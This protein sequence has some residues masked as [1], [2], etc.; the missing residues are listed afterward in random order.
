MRVL[1]IFAFSF[2][3]AVLAAN[4]WLPES[5]LILL[6][7]LMALLGALAWVLLKDRRRPRK[8][9]ALVCGGLALGLL[10]TAAY[11]A[12]FFQPART[13]DDRT[14]R[15]TAVAADWPQETDYGYSV[16]VRAETDSFI[17]LNTILYTDEQGA[18]LRPGDRIAGIVHCT[19]GD[20]TS[21]GRR[22]PI[23]PPRAFF[24]GESFMGGWRL[25]GPIM[26]R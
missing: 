16:L 5:L 19:L 24:F 9:A 20:R 10:W 4:Y 12:L 17:K 6:G 7:L 26:S 13:L 8:A 3:G 22:S 25:G 21:P 23:T 11:T 2:A 1:A 14:V 18:A 15:L